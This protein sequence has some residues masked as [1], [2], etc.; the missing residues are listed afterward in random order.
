MTR[1]IRVHGDAL[2][3]PGIAA[4]IAIALGRLGVRPQDVTVDL[5]DM[6]GRH[7]D[8]VIVDDPIRVTAER[9]DQPREI[10]P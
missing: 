8:T 3:D 1:R 7:P 4:G 10:E 9:L 2:A 5:P 6:T